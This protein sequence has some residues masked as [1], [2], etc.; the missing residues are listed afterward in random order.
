MKF[1]FSRRS[2]A[3]MLALAVVTVQLAR[4]DPPVDA[5][6]FDAASAETYAEI[7]IPHSEFTGGITNTATCS[8]TTSSNSWYLEPDVGCPKTVTVSLPADTASAT[9]AELFLDIWAGRTAHIVRYSIN[10]GTTKTVNAGLDASRTPVVLDVPVG[11][12][13]AGNNTITFSV[14]NSKY[15][16]H[17]AA[18]RLYGVAGNYPT[19]ALGTVGGIAAGTGGTLDVTDTES[20]TITATVPGA[21]RV[22]FIAYYDGFDEDNDGE[23]L[24]WHAFTRMNFNPGGKPNTGY[25]IP[26]QGGTIGHIGTDLNDGDD[27]YSVNWD[28]SLVASQSG[29]RIKARAVDKAT[30]TRLNIADAV[31]GQSAPFNLLRTDYL[32]EYFRDADF[33]DGA[34]FEGGGEPLTLERTMDLPSDLSDWESATMMGLYW[35]IP[36]V[37]WNG[38]TP[39]RTFQYSNNGNPSND[40]FW[41]ISVVNIPLAD[42]VPGSNTITYDYNPSPILFGNQVEAPGPMLVVKRAG[43]LRVDAQPE[44]AAALDGQPVTLSVVTSSL[45]PVSHQW[46]LNNA[47]IAGAT[48]ATLGFTADISDGASQDYRVVMTSGGSIVTS[49]VATLSVITDAFEADDFSDPS[50]SAARWDTVDTVGN[51]GFTFTG[52]QGVISIPADDVNHQPWTG[53]NSS[54]VLRQSLSNTDFDIHA[55]FESV[56]SKR[57]SMQGVLVS[58]GSGPYLR[59]DVYHDGSGVRPFAA[60][61][62]N[63]TGTTKFNGAPI[64][65]ADAKHIRV[66]RV[67]DTF[68]M[69]TSADGAAW[70]ERTSFVYGMNVAE[71][72]VFGGTALNGAASPA[73]TAIVDFVVAVPDGAGG[74]AATDDDSTAPTVTAIS[75]IDGSTSTVLTWT[76]SEPTMG[77]VSY[78]LNGTTETR[79]TEGLGLTHSVQING[80]APQTTY[81]M[82][83]DVEDINGNAAS[84]ATSVTTIA[85]GT[86]PS[87]FDIWYGDVQNFGDQG[88]PQRWINVLG[89]VSDAQ[90]VASL[91]YRLNSGS[92]VAMQM[93]ADGRRL[94]GEGD[95][96]VDIDID[97]LNIGA[98]TVLL[99][100]TDTTGGVTQHTVTVNWTE[101]VEWPLPYVA[102]WSGSG[103]VTN[104][105]QP[106]DGLWALSADGLTINNLDDGYDRLTAIGD[107]AWDQYEVSV[108][109]TV[110]GI[111]PDADD[112]PSNG[113]GVGFILRWQGH[114]DSVEPGS[115]PLVGFKADGASPTPFGTLA[116]W[117]DPKGATPERV[118]MLDENAVVA[119]TGAFTLE[120]GETYMFK[121]RVEGTT[122][123]TYSFKAW[124]MGDVEPVG[125]TASFTASGDAGEPVGGSLTLLS[126]ELD[127]TFGDVV[128]IPAGPVSAEPPTASPAGGIVS[129]GSQITLSSSQAGATIFYTTDG[130]TP[131]AASNV[132]SGPFSIT[133]DTTI[134]S[135]SMVNGTDPSS[136]VT[137][138]YTYNTAPVVSTGPGSTAELGETVLLSGS[139]T[140]DGASGSA[141]VATWS[142][143]SGPGSVTFGNSASPATTVSFSAAGSYVLR[144]QVTDGLLTTSDTVEVVIQDLS[145]PFGYWITSNS[146]QVLHF[147]DVAHHGDLTGQTLAASVAAIEALPGRDGYWLALA[148]GDVVAFG[149]AVDRGNVSHLTLD[150]P[151][152]GMTSTSTGAGYYLLGQDGGIFAFG[153]ADFF[154]ST[155]GIK[156][157]KPITAMAA[158]NSGAGYWFV[159][160]DGGIF[161][162]GPNAPFLGSVPGALGPGRSVDQPVVGMAP[163]A[164]GKGYWLVAADG[165]IFAFGDAGFYNSIPGVLGPD[166]KLAEPIVGMV[167]TESGKGYWLVAADGGVFGFGDA[168][169]LGS[170]AGQGLD[171]VVALS[172]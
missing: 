23:T 3:I 112:S 127:A 98:N 95:F 85:A 78:E 15:H 122:P 43:D 145:V 28:T 59:F 19:G 34:L 166:T 93:G 36:D 89:R 160:A 86:D 75:S 156:L 121:A 80:L 16:I 139:F 54:A 39:Q 73:F 99:T 47:P 83:I 147:G 150:A 113:P 62:S 66:K 168:E 13:V 110:N 10:G 11:D 81:A 45:D 35:S 129:E 46:T 157:D 130:S 97:D 118:E 65:T 114:N 40:D 117:R 67:G 167:A 8:N 63:T 101:G 2:V 1:N 30:G 20:V 109:V 14:N 18:F 22:E 146:G 151:V 120:V 119:D 108:P 102:T 52:A 94:H 32:V 148:N 158:S 74:D 57:F 68:T 131:T 136:V 124:K 72:G 106:V 155:G 125:W 165:G 90:G 61:V 70:T 5:S 29:I 53:G 12:L 41:D 141:P 123:A 170:G 142:K 100:A 51:V 116:F 58:A 77:S 172:N 17:D 92:A 162:F 111:A 134:K 140:D 163:T 128:V 50:A 135:L 44:S 55:A 153:D 159:G 24:D 105:T 69:Y 107:L 88:V 171:R 25:S 82:T 31:G 9:K 26:A 169:F 79:P 96:N 56:P 4:N 6:V 38:G 76:T 164:S 152:V 33:V 71:F 84:T 137:T 149:G 27:T 37:T 115:Q 91:N 48:S 49:D 104:Q 132:Y 21:D 133:A 143:V 144:L 161:A 7:W 126:H 154:G 103:A 87:V 60:I 64:S 138:S 42:L